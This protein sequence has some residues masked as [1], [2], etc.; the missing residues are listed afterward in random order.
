MDEFC[1]Q[2]LAKTL[3]RL[4]HGFPPTKSGVEIKILK[5]IFEPHEAELFCDLR[6]TPETAVQIA[7]RTGRSPERVEKNLSEMWSKGQVHCR[8]SDGVKR[9]SIVPYA[10]GIYEFQI[11]RMDAEF[12]KLSER[13]GPAYSERVY[14]DKPQ[15]MQVVPI[16]KA[17]PLEHRALPY[18]MVSEIINRGVSFG[19][20]ECICRKSRRMIG[21]GCTK[22]LSTCLSIALEKDIFYFP[23]GTRISRSEAFHILDKAEKAALVHLTYNVRDGQHFICNCCGCCCAMLRAINQSKIRDAVNSHNFAVIDKRKCIECGTC[24]EERCQ[25][26]AVEK[27]SEGYFVNRQKCIGCGLCTST[28]PADAISL[29]KKNETDLT[30][31]PKNNRQWY[32]NRARYRSISYD[33]FK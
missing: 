33:C 12:V 32:E 25:V 13:Y 20:H 11:D 5:K 10:L 6:L 8:D 29:A 19:V 9:F 22:P 4:P 21:Q 30:A 23:P 31:P 27:G 24:L 7:R 1:Y 3:D 26:K 28:C 15:L 2:K 17:L 18:E 14:R 16:Q